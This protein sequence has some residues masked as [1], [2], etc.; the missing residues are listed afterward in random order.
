MSD[1]KELIAKVLQGDK[2]FS[3]GIKLIKPYKKTS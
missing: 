1:Q 3:A 2:L